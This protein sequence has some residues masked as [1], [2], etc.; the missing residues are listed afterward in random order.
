MEFSQS[1]YLFSLRDSLQVLPFQKGV[2]MNQDLARERSKAS[3]NV[4][5]LTNLLD[6][7]PAKT[8]RRRYLGK[9]FVFLSIIR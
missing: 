4:E 9:I 5:E 2:K 7:G 1:Y 6:D 3:F 8:A